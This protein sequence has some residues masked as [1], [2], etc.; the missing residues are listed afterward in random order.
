MD[1]IGEL[2]K[3]F[4]GNDVAHGKQWLTG[5]TTPKGKLDSNGATMKSPITRPLWQ[6]HLDGTYMMGI[7]PIK[8]G[9]R[10]VKVCI[11]DVDLYKEQLSP[12]EVINK[13]R[14][15]GLKMIAHRSKS[16]GLH[17]IMFLTDWVD[18]KLAI[19]KLSMIAAFLSFG[20][21]EIF[22]KQVVVKEG[23]YGSFLSLPY[24]KG[25]QH[26]RTAF[27]YEAKAITNMEDYINFVHAN[28]YTPEEFGAIDVRAEQVYPEGPP[29]L[30]GILAED[31]H[32]GIRN[33][34]LF[35]IAIMLRKQ[36]PE[37]W[38]AELEKANQLLR[39]PL[40]ARELQNV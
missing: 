2:M 18:A 29:C 25:N 40:D 6:R 21:H 30:N 13:F 33:D 34:T 16:G 4:D 27:D 9:N 14:S 22:P 39:P 20:T 5:E 28:M 7:L 32:E 10:T 17:L 24:F 35:N 8:P 15:K 31:S 38:E 19:E 1:I 12:I 23:D 3:L 26:L 11:I 36:F 37:D